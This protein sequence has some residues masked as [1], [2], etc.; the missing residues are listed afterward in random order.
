MRGELCMRD[1]LCM[2]ALV[3][4]EGLDPLLLGR[5]RTSLCVLTLLSLFLLLLPQGVIAVFVGILAL[6]AL[7]FVYENVMFLSQGGSLEQML[8]MH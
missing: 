2:R 8:P 4:V 3:T 1:E 6:D 5:S 7:V